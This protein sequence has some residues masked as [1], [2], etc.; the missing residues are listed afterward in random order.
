MEM[1]ADA[2]NTGVP[3]TRRL[4]RFFLPLAVQAASQSLCY[5]L[6]AMVASRGPGGPVN[7]AGLAQSNTVMFFLGI[8]AL[9]LVT[10]GM[11]FA[12][13]RE[14]YRQFYRVTLALG[15]VVSGIQALLCLPW[16]SHLLFG[17]LIGLP[18]S[19]EAPAQVALLA[20]VPLQLLF[21][22]RIPYFVVMYLGKATGAASL[23][24]IGRVIFTAVLSPVF[25]AAGLVGPVWAVVALTLPVALEAVASRLVAGPFLKNLPSSD[26]RPPSLREIFWFNLPLSAG[27]CL[28]SLASMILAAFIAR[29]AEPERVL[30]I[31]Y[32]ALGL[33]NPVA[34]AASR[35]QTIVLVFPPSHPQD[36]QTLRFTLWAGLILGALPLTFLLPGLAEFYYVRLQNLAPADLGL[37]RLTAASLV[38]FPLAVGLRG[39]SEGL[40]AWLQRPA[41]VVKGHAVFVLAVF[42]TGLA[43]LGLS[44]PG[45]FIGTAG[46]TLGSLASSATI[47]LLL[48]RGDGGTPPARRP[49]P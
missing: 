7:L 22:S 49:G 4:T 25:C 23:A 30:P 13:S 29:A 24:T 45:H 15:C 38:L 6:V 21:F 9:S 20:S 31:Y 1:Q 44:V 17:R 10:T 47:H 34:F 37:V 16:V 28:L 8:F 2:M 35:V 39:Q 48:K 12:H 27:G 5:P 11:V 46:L 33:A 43:A 40:A 36:R 3:D 18:P 19:I 32:L 42:A 41:A 14:G 26:A